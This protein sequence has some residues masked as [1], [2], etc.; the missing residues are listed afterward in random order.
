[1]P[2]THLSLHYHLVFSTKNREPWLSPTDR[3]RVHE[4]IGGT[5]RGLNGIAHAVGG[6]GDHVHVFA[7]LRATHC[8]A[9]VMRE[10]KSES[11]AWIHRELR[12]A[13]FAWQDGYGG[14]TVSASKLETVRQ[15]VLNQEEHHRV[16]TFQEEY[17]AMLKR[18]LVAYN[19]AYLW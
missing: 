11:S 10:I 19:E 3:D 14:F 4:Y 7:G 8:L 5:L 2:S 17:V 6:T 16:K 12:M 1:M 15:Y 13:G 18:G 9:D